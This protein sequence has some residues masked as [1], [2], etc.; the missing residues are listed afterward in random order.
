MHA[1]ANASGYYL[2]HVVVLVHAGD[3]LVGR[4]HLG[5]LEGA[6]GVPI[7]TRLRWGYS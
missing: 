6:D 3:H 5:D 1:N 4:E 7:M 2:L